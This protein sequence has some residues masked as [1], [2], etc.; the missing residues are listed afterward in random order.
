MGRLFSI[1]E[2]LID[3]IPMQKGKALKDV[4]S[5][6]RAPGEPQQTLQQLLRDLEQNLQ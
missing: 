1:G 4:Q 5:F 2:V 6:K 3:F